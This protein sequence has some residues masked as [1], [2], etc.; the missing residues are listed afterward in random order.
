MFYFAALSWVFASG[1]NGAGPAPVVETESG[2]VSGFTRPAPSG[3]QAVDIFWTIPYAA[4]PTGTNRFRPPQPFAEPWAPKTRK[5]TTYSETMK[6][7]CLQSTP[8]AFSKGQEDCLYLHVYR[9]H[10]ATRESKLPVFVFLYG[11]G[12]EV[13]DAYMGGLYDGGNLVSQHGFIVVTMN[14]RLGAAGFFA[15]PELRAEEGTT[16]NY[17]TQDQRAGL[18]WVRRNAAR[19]GGDP[20]RVTL[21]GQ[22]AGA[23]S[24]MWHL[25]SPQSQGLFQAAVIMSGTSNSEFFFQA[26]KD[27]FEF[28]DAISTHLG[29]RSGNDRLNCLRSIS[30]SKLLSGIAEIVDILA[31]LFHRQLPSDIPARA[32]ALF[33]VM[34]YG[35]TIDGAQV[36]LVDMPLR[37]VKQG[38]FNRVPLMIGGNRDD[39]HGFG[40]MVPFLWGH[41]KPNMHDFVEWFLPNATDQQRAMALYGGPDFPTDTVRQDRAIRDFI[42]QCPSRALARQWSAAGLAVHAYQFAFD[43]GNS[44]FAHFVGT[45]H[46]TELPFIFRKELFIRGLAKLS[47]RQQEYIDMMDFMSCTWASFVYCAA[48]ACVE[49]PPNCRSHVAWPPFSSE[50]QYMSLSTSSEVK[51]IPA[52]ASFGHDEWAS[53][54][55][56]AFWDSANLPGY[57]D[58]RKA[59]HEGADPIVV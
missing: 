15:L 6:M 50:Q 10:G 17:G 19:F 43:F 7:Q 34:P 38:T 58:M 51:R 14:Y 47:S 46:A 29:C 12:F 53:D 13:G 26:E 42:F 48:P 52:E 23:F 49:K 11:G 2:N 3:G 5:S 59:I 41:S 31:R 21:C 37:L 22:S 4:P 40:S 27:T 33:P 32:S 54:E 1:V 9:P 18:Q 24:V 45:A 25:V 39:G 56:C 35:P 57:R 55:R 8:I 16:G 44:S 36:G 28:Y 30:A 20:Q